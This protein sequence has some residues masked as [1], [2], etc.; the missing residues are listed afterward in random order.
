MTSPASSIDWSQAYSQHEHWL[1]AVVI[2]RVRDRHAADEVLQEVMLAAVR[3]PPG[4][5]SADKVAPWL[6]RVAVRQA[7]LY[8]RRMGRQRKLMDRFVQRN[9]VTGEDVREPDPLEWLLAGER[10]RLVRGALG[11]LAPRDAEILLLK[12]SENWDYHQVA[13]RLGISHSAVETR[14]HRARQRL[15]E[16]LAQVAEVGAKS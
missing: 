6:Y 7:L 8:R 10:H 16:Q 14:L 4:G 12:Y 9:A 5:I 1:R 2:A 3:L 13:A 15:R 11:R